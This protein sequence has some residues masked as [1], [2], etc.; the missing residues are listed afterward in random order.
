MKAIRLHE[1]GGPDVLRLE[2]VPQ[3]KPGPGEIRIRH[4]AIGVNLIDTYHRSGLY[5]VAL[6]SGLGLEAAGTVEEVGPGVT[7][8]QIGDRVGYCSGPLGAYAEA[9]VV[10]ADRAVG[11]PEHLSPEIAAAALLKGMTARYLLRKTHPVGQG[12]VVVIYAAAGGVGQIACQ[13][14]AHLGAV[15]IGIVGSEAKAEQARGNGCAHVLVQGVDDIAKAVRAVSGGEGAR[16]VYDSVGKNTFLQSLDC[17]APMGMLVSFGNASG[18]VPAFSPALL[19]ERGSLF[20]TRPTLFH[21]TR[22]AALLQETADELFGVLEAGIVQ[23]A[24][25]GEYALADATQAH[26]DLHARRTT[27]SVILRA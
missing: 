17:L 13:W 21:Y 6:P 11:L 4:A 8:F 16:V 18:P 25:P 19:A 3:P 10:P 15:V 5:P 14:A 26:R 27:G 7:R 23:I 1:T 2:S 12:D 22:T 24:A 9:H 20:L